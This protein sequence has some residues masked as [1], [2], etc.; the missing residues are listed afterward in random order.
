MGHSEV[1][2]SRFRAIWIR[3]NHGHVEGFDV[4]VHDLNRMEKLYAF[5]KL[6]EYLLSGLVIQGHFIADQLLDRPVGQR[7]VDQE[8]LIHSEH[9]IST[10]AIVLSRVDD[11]DEMTD[12]WLR[13]H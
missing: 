12:S 2:E 1:Y 6:P 9:L 11:V 8:D 13:G 7:R 4:S 3:G 5:K 10:I